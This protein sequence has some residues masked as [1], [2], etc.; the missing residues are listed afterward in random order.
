VYPATLQRRGGAPQPWALLSYL[1]ESLVAQDQAVD[2]AG[3]SNLWVSRE[4]GRCLAELGMS[5]VGIDW[6]DREYRPDR[7]FCAM[8]DIAYNLARLEH[9]LPSE[10]AKILYCTGSDPHYQNAAETERV[11]ALNSRRTTECS[12]RRLVADPELATRSLDA[13]DLAILLGNDHTLAT[14]PQRVR[15]K[16]HQVPAPGSEV[17]ANRKQA[18]TMVPSER[19][20]LWFFGGGAVHKGLDLTLEVFSKRPDFVLNVIGDAPS[21]PDFARAYEMELNRCD[22]IRVH[23]FLRPDSV[24]FGDVSKRC[25]AFLGPSCSEGTSSAVVTCLKVGMYPIITRDCGVTLPA[26]EGTYLEECS[27]DEIEHAVTKVWHMPSSQLLK[28]ISALQKHALETYSRERFSESLRELLA[29]ALESG[30]R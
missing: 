17:G 20:F 26:G 8:V 29:R 1:A 11:R 22:N 30:R 15:S 25:M 7:P 21:E 13:C 24:A 18:D 6:D 28:S 14:Y 23:G 10:A 19:E 9:D 3:H 12:P 2:S 5:V 4:F 27:I 16:M